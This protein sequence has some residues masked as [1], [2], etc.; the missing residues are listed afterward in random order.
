MALAV[1]PENLV[2]RALK[3]LFV[4]SR[5]QLSRH[6]ARLL[7]LPPRLGEK[8]LDYVPIDG[9]SP[10]VVLREDDGSEIHVVIE[11][12]LFAPAQATALTTVQGAPRRDGDERAAAVHDAVDDPSYAVEGGKVNALGVKPQAVWQI[13]AYYGWK[14]WGRDFPE[15]HLAPDA[16]FIYLSLDGG[17]AAAK[18]KGAASAAHWRAVSLV[19]LVLGLNRELRRRRDEGLVPDGSGVFTQDEREAIAVLT[20]LVYTH[21]GGDHVSAFSWVE[22]RLAPGGEGAAG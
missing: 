10:D 5:P 17:T 14:W 13:D 2:N 7:G 21:V 9:F 16:Q 1:S 20:F 3:G 8:A 22:D 12:K 11:T 19:D 4:P 18:Y 6:A 15:L